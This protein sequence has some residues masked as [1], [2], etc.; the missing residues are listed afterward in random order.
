[1]NSLFRGDV[2]AFSSIVFWS[3]F[4]VVT[5]LSH[6]TFP[7]LWSAFFALALSCLFFGF[8]ALFFRHSFSV[9]PSDYLLFLW[10]I[11]FNGIC[12]YSLMFYGLQ[13][14]T[15]GNGAILSLL[16]VFFSYIIL[17][18][19]FRYESFVATQCIGAFF[20]LFGAFW[21]L[22]PQW[23]NFAV[24]DLFIILA[25][26]FPSFGNPH[27]QRLRSRYHSSV[28][29]F[30]RTL[31]SLPLFFV[32]AYAIHGRLGISSVSF[33]DLLPF[34]FSGFFVLGYS[35]ILWLDALLQS[36]ITRAVSFI[37]VQPFI[38]LLFSALL[39]KESI[40]LYQL[41]S[42]PFFILGVLLI[43]RTRPDLASDEVEP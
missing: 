34:L 2:L 4:P 26:I 11:L 39:L 16:E 21:L 27:M 18:F 17:T 14:T 38:T 1:M 25:T 35:K 23:S 42:L 41:F 7:P 43:V 15:A 20:I 29:F 9:H 22:F 6:H 32:F 28:I 8:Y 24:G 19:L 10:V 30:W 37:G 33:F 31:F 36:S 5:K 40:T 12:Y 3:L 13:Y